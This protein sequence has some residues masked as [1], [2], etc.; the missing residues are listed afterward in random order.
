MGFEVDRAIKQ[1]CI[2]LL[3]FLLGLDGFGLL[4]LLGGFFLLVLFFLVLLL[5]GIFRSLLSSSGFGFVQVDFN[6]FD[7]GFGFL[8][9]RAIVRAFAH[10]N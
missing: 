9:F 3:Y 7:G 1:L 2:G 10:R 5:G 8:F 4:G 6:G